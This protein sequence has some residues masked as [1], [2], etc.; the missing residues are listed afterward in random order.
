VNQRR[1]AAV[2]GVVAF[3]ACNVYDS[4]LLTGDAGPGGGGSTASGGTSGSAGSD[5]G[6]SS[7]T[8]TNG[9]TSGT[10]GNTSPEGGAAGDDT[11]SGGATTGGSS[12]SS[13]GG[14]AGE[15]G[16]TAGAANSGTGG[17]P[18][19]GSGGAAGSGAGSSGAG[20][21]GGTGGGMGGMG[22][23]S[24]AP[25][26]GAGMGGSGGSGGPIVQLTG[27]ATADSEQTNP[28]HPAVHGNDGMTGTRWCAA[29]GST[30]HYWTVDLGAVHTLSRFEV[31]WEYPNQ[32]TGLAYGYVISVSNDGT[33]FTTAINRTTNTDVMQTQSSDFPA[34]T[35]GRHARITV[36]ALPAS[37]PQPTWA[38]FFEAR[39]FGQ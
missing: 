5:I 37:T 25:V 7:G 20:N 31:M 12:G 16:G 18:G 32:A 1:F 11:P 34:S 13:T 24:G 3:G 23:A 38:S 39:V 27:T 29:N 17:M 6:G 33:T 30:G 36:V 19:A 22:G 10:G 9:G 2:L 4:S 35:T 8:M 26:G 15:T 21:E 28:V 14:S